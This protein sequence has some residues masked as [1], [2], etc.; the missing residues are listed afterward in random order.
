VFINTEP[1]P[2]F[3]VLFVIAM[4][5]GSDHMLG[6]S[7]VFEILGCENKKMTLESSNNSKIVC[8]NKNEPSTELEEFVADLLLSFEHI[9]SGLFNSNAIL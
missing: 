5:L 7:I 1:Q 8:R 2:P 6:L 4:L 3:L 9:L